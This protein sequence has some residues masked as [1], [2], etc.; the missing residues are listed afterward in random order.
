MISAK[1]Q[2]YP[3]RSPE[4]YI[5][6]EKS[7]VSEGGECRNQIRTSNAIERIRK[8]SGYVPV[9]G[10]FT[11]GELGPDAVCGP[12]Q[13]PPLTR[14]NIDIPTRM[15]ARL[16]RLTPVGWLENGYVGEML[17]QQEVSWIFLL[18]GPEMPVILLHLH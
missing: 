4:R 11:D 18:A 7:V 14:T 13:T 6:L 1:T 16:R 8:R 10:T 17:H 9:V 3:H 2:T 15:F 12:T 5:L